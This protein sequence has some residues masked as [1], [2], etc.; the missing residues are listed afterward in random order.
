MYVTGSIKVLRA[1]VFY[2]PDR[3]EN[4][5]AVD[6]QVNNITV[7][8]ERTYA[9]QQDCIVGAVRVLLQSCC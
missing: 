4:S 7:F 3:N 9:I 1:P 2:T 6:R 5:A 8:A